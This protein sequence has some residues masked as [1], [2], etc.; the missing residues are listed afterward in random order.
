MRTFMTQKSN[1]RTLS[2]RGCSLNLKGRFW[3]FKATKENGANTR[4]C[5]DAMEA[6][7]TF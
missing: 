5:A 6:K 3:R 4:Y 1:F 2:A 7:I